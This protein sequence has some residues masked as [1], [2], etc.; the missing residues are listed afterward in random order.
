MDDEELVFEI[1]V[2]ANGGVRMEFTSE[3]IVISHKTEEQRV[4]HVIGECTA[5]QPFDVCEILDMIRQFP[6]GLIVE[7]VHNRR[8]DGDLD[9]LDPEMLAKGSDEE[10]VSRNSLTGNKYWDQQAPKL[11]KHAGFSKFL[12]ILQMTNLE[13]VFL[14]RKLLYLNKNTVYTEELQFGSRVV[15]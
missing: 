11:E 3:G 5:V 9:M 14:L 8:Y 12:D 2:P 1:K 4:A 6:E 7:L 15:S 10:Q 13:T